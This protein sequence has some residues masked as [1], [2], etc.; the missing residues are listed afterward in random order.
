MTS[1][2]INVLLIS[3]NDQHKW[4][5]WEETTPLIKEA[6]EE[7]GA[8]HVTVSYD[9]ESLAE[10][11]LLAF[12]VIAFNYCNWQDPTELS[13]QAKTNVIKFG[14]RG[15]GIVI[16]HF[17]NGAFHF[18]LPEAGQSDWPE[19]HRIVP[20]AWN[21]HGK[22]RHD[23]YGEFE[24]FI[25]DNTHPITEGIASFTIT[26]ELYFDQE[27]DVDI[28]PLYAAHSK[29]TGKEEPL[30]WVSEYRNSRVYQTLLGHD[31]NAYL[32]PEVRE[33]LRRSVV[34]VTEKE[35]QS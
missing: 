29:I 25:T 4:H 16:L 27:G 3:G 18:S 13:E 35:Q 5:N 23:K 32:V 26:D 21:H 9:I 15:G 8:I 22:S 17:A 19:Y 7:N 30:A 24:V 6:L 31:R 14:E 34:W 2:H 11:S 12:D 28:H 10:E 1:K 33:I 20:R